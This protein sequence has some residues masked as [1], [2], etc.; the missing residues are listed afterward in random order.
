MKLGM[1]YDAVGRG[2]TDELHHEFRKPK[3]LLKVK[4]FNKDDIWS[5]DLVEMPKEGKFKYILTVI[6]LYT[7]YAWAIPLPDKKGQTVA[8]AFQAITNEIR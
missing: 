5:A 3:H 2:Y 8:Q 7:R 4:V 6:D 1:G